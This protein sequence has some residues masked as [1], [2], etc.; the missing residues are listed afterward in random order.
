[1]SV[2]ILGHFLDMDE[3]RPTNARSFLPSSVS[4]S[5]P[6]RLPRAA[7]VSHGLRREQA[8]DD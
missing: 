7:G 6:D 3:K 5:C 8:Q 4:S 2:M 1:M